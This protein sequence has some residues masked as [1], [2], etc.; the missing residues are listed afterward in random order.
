MTNWVCTWFYTQ[1]QDEGGEYAQVRGDSSTERFRDVYRRCVG[2]FFLSAR[3]AN[4]DANLVLYVNTP[5]ASHRSKV[6]AD[7]GS[8]LSRLN[9]KVEVIQYKHHP[10]QSFAKS[11]KNQF[12]VL[13][14]LAHLASQVGRNDAWLV[15]DSDIVWSTLSTH[16][17]WRT[18]HSSGTST[19]K[20]GY[21]TSKDINGISMESLGEL[22]TN[23]GF[24]LQGRLDYSGGEFVGGNGA[25]IDA[26]CERSHTIWSALMAKHVR[27]QNLQFEEAHLLSLTYSSLGVDLGGMDAFIRRLWTQPFKYQN[28]DPEDSLLALWH[29]PA[30]KK[31]GIRRLYRSAIRNPVRVLEMDAAPWIS[32]C[33]KELGIPKNPLLKVARDVTRAIGG[34]FSDTVTKSAPTG[35][36]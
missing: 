23:L 5:W 21:E 25:S 6:A 28:V 1:S 3:K 26:L 24:D 31:Y 33:R 16:D 19:Y 4:P 36:R 12:F 18:L 27:D 14:V 29:V 10:P 20:V 32:Q 9:V 2:V 22:G 17:L 11:W 13:D 35:R 8:L 30:E 15:L 7:V 34:K